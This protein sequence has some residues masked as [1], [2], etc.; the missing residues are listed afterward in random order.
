MEGASPWIDERYLLTVFPDVDLAVLRLFV[1]ENTKHDALT[2][3]GITEARLFR[4][5]LPM[6]SKHSRVIWSGRGRWSDQTGRAKQVD[7]VTQA[8]N[9][10]C[11]LL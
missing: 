9:S 5:R 2:D 10:R 7:K 11:Q 6:F 8:H 4:S 1:K 3:T